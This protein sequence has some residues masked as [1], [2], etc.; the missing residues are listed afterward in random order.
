MNKKDGESWITAD[1]IN[2][3]IKDGIQTFGLSTILLLYL[4]LKMNDKKTQHFFY[5]SYDNHL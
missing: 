3:L 5:Y 4:K 1:G 2:I